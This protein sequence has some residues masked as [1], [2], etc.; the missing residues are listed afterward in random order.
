MKDL[1]LDLGLAFIFG[2]GVCWI[3]TFNLETGNVRR[4]LGGHVHPGYFRYNK[5]ERGS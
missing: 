4:W 3:A 5:K 1:L 2:W